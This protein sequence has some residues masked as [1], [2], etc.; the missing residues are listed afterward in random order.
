MRGGGWVG[1]VVEMRV[2]GGVGLV[3]ARGDEGV[4]GVGWAVVQAEARRFVARA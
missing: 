4:G 1:A 3:W 2:V